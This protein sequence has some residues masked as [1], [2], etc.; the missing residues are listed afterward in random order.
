[1]NISKNKKHKK[2]KFTYYTII[3]IQTKDKENISINKLNY[4]QINKRTNTIL[5]QI[6]NHPKKSTKLNNNKKFVKLK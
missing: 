6:E 1:M 3:V 4:K 2:T 5:T